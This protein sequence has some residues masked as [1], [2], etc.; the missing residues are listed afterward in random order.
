MS[1]LIL[2]SKVTQVVC[3]YINIFFA[4]EYMTD[5]AIWWRKYKPVDF[6]WFLYLLAHPSDKTKQTL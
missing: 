2:I 4:L 3:K 6:L 1:D 5:V